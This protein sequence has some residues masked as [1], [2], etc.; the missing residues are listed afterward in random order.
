MERQRKQSLSLSPPPIPLSNKKKEKTKK[1]TA[2]GPNPAWIY[3]R[4]VY[5]NNR[6]HARNDH[7]QQQFLPPFLSSP[8][9]SSLP[10]YLSFSYSHSETLRDHASKVF[11]VSPWTQYLSYLFHLFIF[12]TISVAFIVAFL[13]LLFFLKHYN[14]CHSMGWSILSVRLVWPKVRA[15][16]RGARVPLDSGAR[17]VVAGPAPLSYSKNI[18]IYTPGNRAPGRGSARLDM[19]EKNENTHD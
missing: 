18:N 4:N 2:Q 10:I 16:H 5:L 1:T 15:Q 19:K 17:V 8:H 9:F 3:R 6:V 12:R 7:L 14:G 13:F 11:N